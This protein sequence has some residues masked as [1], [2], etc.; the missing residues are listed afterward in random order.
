M[1]S[2]NKSFFLSNLEI[3]GPYPYQS[4]GIL[5]LD[6]CSEASSQEVCSSKLS[7]MKDHYIAI[8]VLLGGLSEN[9]EVV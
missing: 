4:R 5:D 8:K 9:G 2:Q 1:F 3:S 7:A 6:L